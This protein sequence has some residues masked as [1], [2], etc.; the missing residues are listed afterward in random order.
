MNVK[1]MEKSV[2][3]HDGRVM[4]MKVM[5]QNNILGIN[6][7]RKKTKRPMRPSHELGG[8]AAGSDSAVAVAIV[9][10]KT[11]IAADVTELAGSEEEAMM[12]EE[13]VTDESKVI[14][15]LSAMSAL[16]PQS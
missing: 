14:G 5:S 2:N 15:R 13:E 1:L 6:R 10:F 7:R 4:V 16:Q 12:A 8:E 3:S 11:A 9:S